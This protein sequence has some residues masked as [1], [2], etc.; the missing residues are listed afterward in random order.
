[1]IMQ[2]APFLVQIRIKMLPLIYK[3]CN[4]DVHLTNFV[5]LCNEV[6]FYDFVT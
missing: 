6:P 3:I 4:V 5:I 2:N 1:M